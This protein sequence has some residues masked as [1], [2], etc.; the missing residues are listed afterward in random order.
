MSIY[1]VARH[2][3]LFLDVPLLCDSDAKLYG[4]ILQLTYQCFRTLK[5]NKLLKVELDYFYILLRQTLDCLSVISHEEMKP[6]VSNF[7]LFV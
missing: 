2:Y 5:V 7:V 4:H 3:N 1:E 6:P